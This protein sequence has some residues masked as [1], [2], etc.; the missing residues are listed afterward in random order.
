MSRLRSGNEDR[1]D[2]RAAMVTRCAALLAL[3]VSTLASTSVACAE[4]TSA[5]L[6]AAAAR[7]REQ[8]A[9]CLNA[10]G[11]KNA[12]LSARVVNLSTGDVVFEQE[13]ERAVIPASV[14]KMIVIAAAL[15][16]LGTDHRFVTRV[17]VSRSDLILIGAGDPT[18]GDEKLCERRN[19]KATAVLERWA[20]VLRQ[21]GISRIPGR[22]LIDDSVFDRQFT[23]PDWPSD[24]YQEWYSAP[25]GGLNFADNCV[26][27]DVFAR[28]D[29]VEISLFPPNAFVRL[30]NQARTG[31][32]STVTARRA[33]GA[34]EITVR[35]TVARSG[36]L[37]PVAVTDPGLFAAGCVRA[38]FASRGIRIE[39]PTQRARIRRADGSLP[40]DVRIVAETERCITEATQRAGQDSLGMMAEAL[41]KALGAAR[42]GVGS[43]AT[44]AAAVSDFLRELGARDSA[45]VTDDGSGLS[46]QNRLSARIVTDVLAYMSA[47]PAREAFLS[48]LA[49]AGVSGTLKK[50][51]T[52]VETRGRVFAKTGY[53]NG[54]RTL[55]GYVRAKNGD[56]FAFAFL[57][58]GAQATLPLSRAQDEACRRIAR[59]P[60]VPP[61]AAP[62]RSTAQK[63][64]SQRSRRR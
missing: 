59:W 2:G 54:V 45:F 23:N 53:I 36:R 42:D 11:Q 39:G 6:R 5:D 3:V 24:Q 29:R 40:S 64:E 47:R 26:E 19:E 21:R 37:G 43:F 46:R 49:E 22:L 20:Y 56:L 28:G 55:A 44:G 7:L 38:V 62:L 17:G 33:R 8:L 15:E 61:S 25:V 14:M 60:D 1:M 13:A 58:N 18:L 41:F 10:H 27:L 51:L 12:V 57:Y 35:G 31:A 63:P 16:R 48:S 32:K 50:R 52:G 34:S 9:R 30:V 4:P